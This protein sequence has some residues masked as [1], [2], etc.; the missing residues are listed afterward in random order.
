MVVG[1]LRTIELEQGDELVAVNW[2]VARSK[3]F[4]EIVA[5]SENDTTNLRVIVFS[6]ITPKYGEEWYARAMIRTKLRGWSVWV[7]VDIIT[8]N[9]EDS[10]NNITAL[11]SAISTPN[12]ITTSFSSLKQ[13]DPKIDITYD[14]HPLTGFY[15]NVENSFKALGDAKLVATSW[16]MEDLNDQVVWKRIYD[17]KN[18]ESVRFD[19]II[20]DREKIYR[21]RAVFHSDTKDVSDPA[22]YR[23]KT[24][25]DYN[26]ALRV[27]LEH[28]FHNNLNTKY[29]EDGLPLP[30]PLK[31]GFS[32]VLPYEADI[33]DRWLRIVKVE[34][35]DTSEVFNLHLTDGNRDVNIAPGVLDVNSEYLIFFK[36]KDSD[37]EDTIV[38]NTYEYGYNE[39]IPEGEDDRLPEVEATNPVP[40]TPIKLWGN[41]L[42]K[43]GEQVRFHATGTYKMVNFTLQPNDICE[44]IDKTKHTIL[45]KI[46]QAGKKVLLLASAI[47]VPEVSATIRVEGDVPQ[48]D[49]NIP[50]TQDEQQDEPE[51][52]LPEVPI[53]Q[54]VQPKTNLVTDPLTLNLYNYDF[55]P[56]FLD[57]LKTRE[58]TQEWFNAMQE[59]IARDNYV[60]VPI[61]TWIDGGYIKGKT[62]NDLQNRILLLVTILMQS[63]GK[64]LLYKEYAQYYISPERVGFTHTLSNPE[65]FKEFMVDFI[66]SMR[67]G[68]AGFIGKFG[69]PFGDYND[70]TNRDDR[71]NAERRLENVNRAQQAIARRYF[72]GNSGQFVLDVGRFN[73]LYYV[74]LYHCYSLCVSNNI[75]EAN[76][77]QFFD[78]I[79]RDINATP[80]K[81]NL[82][83]YEIPRDLNPTIQV[84]QPTSYEYPFYID[85]YKIDISP[86]LREL[87]DENKRWEYINA[88]LLGHGISAITNKD[89]NSQNLQN[90]FYNIN[91]A[92]MTGDNDSNM[93]VVFN[94]LLYV[95]R[96]LV[97]KSIFVKVCQEGEG[98]FEFKIKPDIDYVQWLQK[99]VNEYVRSIGTTL[100]NKWFYNYC[101]LEHREEHYKTYPTDAETY[102]YDLFY[103]R[104]SRTGRNVEDLK[105]LSKEATPRQLDIVGKTYEQ[106]TNH[107]DYAAAY[108]EKLLFKHPD[109]TGKDLLDYRA[110]VFWQ[111]LTARKIHTFY[112]PAMFGTCWLYKHILKESGSQFS[113]TPKLELVFNRLTCGRSAGNETKVYDIKV[114]TIPDL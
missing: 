75:P 91:G 33:T 44:V 104:D 77:R 34:N 98:N 11:P 74:M 107:F 29:G 46:N 95:Y 30:H 14:K 102:F 108:M 21:V 97:I 35:G 43:V 51:I 42:V 81:N 27:F 63:T 8:L 19:G 5:K 67:I 64:Y 15:L 47:G 86:I 49:P 68:Q 26:Y 13:R 6:D 69:D 90:V 16:W 70:I 110:F 36:T 71:V 48:A 82:K 10:L 4:K 103:G 20:L 73:F 109:K 113:V 23:F 100:H 9:R 87:K 92:T 96:M 22:S 114:D 79:L 83:N 56:I 84:L 1:I 18:L 54:I 55:M 111:H 24:I 39:V 31:S 65:K 72:N 66:K 62:D 78:Q 3:N 61:D 60:E 32:F 45:F 57:A 17:T 40:D 2:Q 112:L 94:I 101:W 41:T 59:A 25:G 58:K 76:I 50:T 99:G 38:L 37:P 88:I 106:I 105:R 28:Q 52:I 7:G 89:Y 53:V 85:L 12:L 93:V 80:I